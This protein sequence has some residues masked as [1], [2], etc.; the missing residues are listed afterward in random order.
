M[1][2]M[3]IDASVSQCSKLLSLLG[4]EQ[5][6]TLNRL[7]D[8]GELYYIVGNRLNAMNKKDLARVCFDISTTLGH[9]DSISNKPKP[10]ISNG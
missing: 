2:R 4:M 8:L 1:D 5:S 7:V 10:K 6:K 3:E 9:N